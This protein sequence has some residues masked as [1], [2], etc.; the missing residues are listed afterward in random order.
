MR[1]K[2]NKLSSSSSM[3]LIFRQMPALWEPLSLVVIPNWMHLG[4]CSTSIYHCHWL[5]PQQLLI[6]FNHQRMHILK[7]PVTPLIMS[8]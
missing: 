1:F 8:F 2:N 4:P 7:C 5:I 6:H 3:M